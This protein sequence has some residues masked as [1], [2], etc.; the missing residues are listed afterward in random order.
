VQGVTLLTIADLLIACEIQ[1]LDLVEQFKLDE[2]PKI[3]SWMKSVAEKCPHWQKS[4]NE[5]LDFSKKTKLLVNQNSERILIFGGTGVVGREVVSAMSK[6]NVKLFST[7]RKLTME[8][9]D[10]LKQTGLKE[11]EVISDVNIEDPSTYERALV[12][13][14]KMFFTP[15]NNSNMVTQSKILVDTAIKHGV[16]YIALLSNL[17]TIKATRLGSWHRE[18]EEYIESQKQQI[19]FTFLRSNISFSQIFG[20]NDNWK[21][22][23]SNF[24]ALSFGDSKVS[25]VDGT[26]VA[27]LVANC[28]TDPEPHKNKRYII[29][30]PDSLG[31][32]EIATLV[33][34]QIGRT[35]N[36]QDAKPEEWENHTINKDQVYKAAFTEYLEWIRNGN[37]T[38]VSDDL[39]KQLGLNPLTFK[40]F[41]IISKFN[42]STK[43]N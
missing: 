36:V 26:N 21:N 34:Q 40:D 41:I 24:L 12:N 8:K 5:F 35:I 9:V 19:S 16:Q 17:D 25:L 3:Q 32:E 1:S 39:E 23:K 22:L 4:T 15:C 38:S 13:V 11:H 33:T 29:T 42:D 7:L 43:F 6:R 2:F 30:G 18:I 37:G 14:K 31:S 27:E 20:L 28:L 10:I